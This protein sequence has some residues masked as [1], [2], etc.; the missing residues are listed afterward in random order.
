[1]KMGT[2]VT[3][4][5][6]SGSRKSSLATPLLL[7]LVLNTGAI[8]LFLRATAEF[9]A[10]GES[11]ARARRSVLVAKLLAPAGFFLLRFTGCLR[12]N[13]GAVLAPP[14]WRRS[15]LCDFPVNPFLSARCGDCMDSRL[16][17]DEGRSS[18]RLALVH[19]L[20]LRHSN[21][22][23]GY[24]YAATPD[25]GE[26]DDLL[27]ETFLIVTRKA[28]DFEP[29]TDFLA[30]TRAIIRFQVLQVRRAVVTQ[31]QTLDADVIDLLLADAAPIDTGSERVTA[32]LH[33]L[34]KLSPRVRQAVDLR[35][36]DGRKSADIADLL[37]IAKE[38]VY[39]MLSRA[40]ESL[41][42]CIDQRLRSQEVAHESR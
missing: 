25:L 29:G 41:R 9:S 19:Q 1:M 23:R 18:D 17:N 40:R 38:T 30:W 13:I 11:E 35:Y 5:A 24:L 39:V 32:L 6:L 33:C 14:A 42:R 16:N 4:A 36:G 15:Q 12:F 28:V 7:I 8:F 3:I 26:L 20:F 21:T 37:S 34:D 10:T 22:I 27:Q 31:P 2:S